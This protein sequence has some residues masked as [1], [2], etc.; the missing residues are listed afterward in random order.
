[1][2]SHDLCFNTVATFL[3]ALQQADWI[4]HPIELLVSSG[5]HSSLYSLR[6]LFIKDS[7]YSSLQ[8]KYCSETSEERGDET[9][10]Y[11]DCFWN[12]SLGEI[13]SLLVDHKKLYAN[14]GM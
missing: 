10:L 14:L 9:R 6:Y 5:L 2:R 12:Q 1:M 8:L 4:N 3:L 13:L 7:G 11:F